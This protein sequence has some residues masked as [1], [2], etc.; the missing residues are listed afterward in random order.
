MLVVRYD[1]RRLLALQVLLCV[2]AHSAPWIRTRP[3]QQHQ[4]SSPS[5]VRSP[6]RS[7]DPTG[8]RDPNAQFDIAKVQSRTTA[9]T[10]APTALS[11]EAAAENAFLSFFRACC[12]NI[13]PRLLLRTAASFLLAQLRVVNRDEDWNAGEVSR[14]VGMS[15]T[16]KLRKI[17]GDIGYGAFYAFDKFPAMSRKLL[18]YGM[19]IFCTIHG[20]ISVVN[21][22]ESEVAAERAVC[23]LNKVGRAV[24]VI[25]HV[26]D[27]PFRALLPECFSWRDITEVNPLDLIVFGPIMEE[28]LCRFLVRSVWPK[29]STSQFAAAHFSNHYGEDIKEGRPA[30]PKIDQSR[31]ALCHFVSCTI[32]SGDAFCPTYEERGLAASIGAHAMLNALV[33]VSRSDFGFGTVIFFL[34]CDAVNALERRNSKGEVERGSP[35]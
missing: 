6:F 16:D 4:K 32:A 21:F 35:C 3:P 9:S 1:L 20:I 23:N 18:V 26:V 2:V 24:T 28:F 29:V 25:S 5:P 34:I 31:K 11:Q 22:L 10:A 15:V 19:A 30:S 27:L 13:R 7:C 8:L 12:E 17:A 33:T 14:S